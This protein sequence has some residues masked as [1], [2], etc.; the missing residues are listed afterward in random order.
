[1]FDEALNLGAEE[2][3]YGSI[4]QGSMERRLLAALT[5]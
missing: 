2:K 5:I 4:S 3:A 1:V